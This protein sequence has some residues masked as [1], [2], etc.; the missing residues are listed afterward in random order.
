MN[1]EEKQKST[2]TLPVEMIDSYN[3]AYDASMK[4]LDECGNDV[5]LMTKDDSPVV[6]SFR[7][8]DEYEKKISLDFPEM[9]TNFVGE[10]KRMYED[11]DQKSNIQH[12]YYVENIKDLYNYFKNRHIK[13]I[14]K[15]FNISQN[16]PE[17]KI[18]FEIAENQLNNATKILL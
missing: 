16:D 2:F 10:C 9:Y 18:L 3:L 17:F 8:R 13:L 14:K 15:Y 5:I 4:Y 6:L 7:M 1:K 12:L 11:F